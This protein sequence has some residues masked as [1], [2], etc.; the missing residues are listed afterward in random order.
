MSTREDD[1]AHVEAW[2]KRQEYAP[3]RPTWLPAGKNPDYWAENVRLN[4][5]NLWVEVKSIEPDDSTATL[6]RHTA[7]IGGARVPAGLR[8]HAMVE[9]EPG[10]V[11]QAVRWCLKAFTDRSP[12]YAGKKVTLVFLQQE[13]APRGEFRITI[14][15]DPEIVIWARADELPLDPGTGVDT[16]ALLQPARARL[17]DGTEVAGPAYRFL[18]MREPKECA[19]VARLDPVGPKLDAVASMCGGVGQTRDRTARAIETANRQIKAACAI[20][21]AAGLVVLTPTGP[22]GDNDQMM[23]AAL[24]GHYTVPITQRGED[25]DHGDLY[26]GADGVFRPTKNTHVSA[27]VHL[28]R[29]GPATFFP[30]PYARIVIPEN[31]DLFAGA[32]RADVEFT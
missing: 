3:S 18:E 14:D 28:R 17:P 22:F 6:A 12:A 7:L 10:A 13:R 9:L 23:Q 1:E 4:P 27:A 15:A 24:Y 26:H 32:R 29:E 20:R 31:A 11:E 21:D 19:L 25:L 30:N 5:A 2:L 16:D 8:G